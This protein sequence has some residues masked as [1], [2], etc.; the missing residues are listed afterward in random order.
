MSNMLFANNCNTILNGGITAVATSMVVTSATGFPVPTG[1][2]YF[3]CT[4]ADAATQTTIEIVKVTAVSGTTFTIVRGQD[5]TTGTIFASGDVVSLR[6]VRA[7]LNDFPKLDEDNTF[8]G[9][10]AY[11]TPASITLTNGSNLPI[12]A[13][14]TG[15]LTTARGGT[16]LTSFTANG[17]VYASSTSALATGTGLTFDGTSL[18]VNTIKVGLGGGSI[19]TN[20]AI[21]VSSLAANTTAGGNTSVGYQ[22][23][24]AQTTGANNSYFGYQAG[25]SSNFTGTGNTG[26][27]LFGYQAG[28]GITTGYGLTCI[29]NTAG[30]N[31]T[32]GT[33]CTVIG[34]GATASAA[35]AVNEVTI[36]S[37]TVTNNRLRGLVTL[38]APSSGSNGT[39]I[40]FPAT[41]DASTDPNTLDDYE[42][43]TFTP[44][45]TDGTTSVNGD[46][47]WYRKIGS[48]VTVGVVFYNKNIS[49]LLSY[50]NPLYVGN[51]PF[52]VASSN[53]ICILNSNQISKLPVMVTGVNG[54]TRAI[55]QSDFSGPD[56]TVL[57]TAA[58]VNPTAI[59]MFGQFTYITN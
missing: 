58:F 46:T 4:L 1:S 25:F 18:T 55:L 23:G 45:F 35:N 7:S 34:S 54:T 3:Y 57:Y 33:N 21:G 37:A 56:A 9:A 5:G 52:T 36:G 8:S 39:G 24:I 20:T 28:Y 14:T 43:G 40:A 11:G 42:E 38:T 51:L 26:N 22:A 49:G 17:V 29:G 32:I 30:N 41:Q 27:S 48:Q 10:N 31:L 16:N 59:S 15:T 19:S 12:V 13:G 6:L 47:C 44:T 50:P 2:Q 53:S